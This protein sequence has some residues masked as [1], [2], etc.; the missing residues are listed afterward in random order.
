V[1]ETVICTQKEIYHADEKRQDGQS[2]GKAATEHL[3]LFNE[4]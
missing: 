3:S 1:I 4:L 2:N